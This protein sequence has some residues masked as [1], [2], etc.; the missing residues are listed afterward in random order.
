MFKDAFE[1]FS[2]AAAALLVTS[3][4]HA[5]VLNVGP[6]QTYKTIASA[7]AASHDGDTISVAAGTY[8]DDFAEI[9]TK[10][11]LVAAG[12]RVTMRADDDIPNGKGILITDTDISITG[13]TFKGAKVTNGDGENG[14]GIRYQSGN[15]V[16]SKC[17]FLNNQEGLLANPASSGSI[18]INSS[19]FDHNGDR[20]GPGAGYTHNIYVDQISLLNIQNSYFHD[21]VIGHEI[22]SRAAKT[23]I[24]ATRV[25]DGPTGTSSYSIDLPN[26]GAATITATS[27][28]QGRRSGNPVI[29]SYGEE[30]SLQPN[31]ILTVGGNTILNDLTAHIPTAVVN[32]TNNTASITSNQVWGLTSSQIVTGPANQSGTTYLSTKPHFPTKHPF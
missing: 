26:G 31:S 4:L 27:I 19:E 5:A 24:N 16:L 14:A 11:S 6:S 17:Y 22:K 30:G 7:V 9:R 2:A 25:M 21:A 12:G 20:T 32:D 1:G 13:F 18:T 10:I 15:L 8:T 3:P 29:I 28:Q 23:I